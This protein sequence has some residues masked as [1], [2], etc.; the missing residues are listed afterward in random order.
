[1]LHFN[2]NL[3]INNFII[4]FFILIIGT[5][6]I[7]FTNFIDGIDGILASN[8]LIAFLHLSCLNQDYKL[9]PLMAGILAFLFLNKAPAKLFM[10]DIGSTFLGAIFFMK[11]IELSDY[12]TAFLSLSAVFPI[13]I[14]T[15]ICVIAR[16]CNKENIFVSHKKHLYQRLVTS[17]L[18]HN[19]VT[20]IYS[21]SSALICLSCY[22]N[23]IKIVSIILILI[24][25]IGLLLN[26]FIASSFIERKN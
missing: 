25:F 19:K 3:P 7:N 2:L 12:R 15:T 22:T 17:G 5:A 14:D 20:I 11:I 18:S 1:M 24:F 23:N 10:G 26:Y 8:M 21:L 6:I 13:Y 4:Y 9:Y 16:F